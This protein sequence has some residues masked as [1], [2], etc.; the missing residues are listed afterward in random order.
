MKEEIIAWFEDYSDD[1]F[2]WAYHKTSSKEIAEDLVQEAFLSAVKGHKHF[3]QE[4]QPKTW[5]YSIL[6]HKIIDHYRKKGRSLA[7]SNEAAQKR[8]LNQTDSFFDR[9]GNWS[10][11][12]DAVLWEEDTHILDDPEF[13]E[14]FY[15]CINDL[16]EK[17]RFAIK[18]KYVLNEEAGYICQELGVTPS[19]Y[20]QMVHR[21][22]LMLKKCIDKRWRF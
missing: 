16:P 22:K 14:T 19:N 20:W 2:Q 15:F 18:A 3:K 17:W 12:Q 9:K 8:A 6:N 5:L 7:V 1:M 11:S 13:T 4:S 10:L 21:A